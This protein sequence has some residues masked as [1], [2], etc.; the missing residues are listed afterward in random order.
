MKYRTE[1]GERT[2]GLEW[3]PQFVGCSAIFTLVRAY[4]GDKVSLSPYHNRK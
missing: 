1:G 4:L 2:E 3:Q